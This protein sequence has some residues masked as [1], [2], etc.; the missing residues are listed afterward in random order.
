MHLVQLH[1]SWLERGDYPLNF[2]GV[3]NIGRYIQHEL[4]AQVGE[5][6]SLQR[7]LNCSLSH[8]TTLWLS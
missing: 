2:L 5:P 1:S 8:R 3:G 7:L 4:S 6:H